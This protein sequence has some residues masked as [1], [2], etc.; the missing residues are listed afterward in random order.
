MIIKPIQSWMINPSNKITQEIGSNTESSCPLTYQSISSVSHID[1][2]KSHIKAKS[3]SLHRSVHV[4]LRNQIINIKSFIKVSDV[5]VYQS[6]LML[7]IIYIVC[8]MSCSGSFFGTLGLIFRIG[9]KCEMVR[10]TAHC[11][12]VMTSQT[13]YISDVPSSK[14]DF[15]Q[16]A[17]ELKYGF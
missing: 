11:A 12:A 3:P 13:G 17:W 4:T 14:N 5:I 8:L 16:I 10:L 2:V 15:S 9:T 7:I 6:N 1:N